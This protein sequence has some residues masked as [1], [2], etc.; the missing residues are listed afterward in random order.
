M[1]YDGTLYGGMPSQMPPTVKAARILLYGGAGLA[2]MLCAALM[3]AGFTATE[4]GGLT[5]IPLTLGITGAVLA[6][7]MRPGRR[8]IR[9]ALNVVEGVWTLLA[10]GAAGQGDPTGPVAMLFS[11]AVLVLINTRTARDYFH[12]TAM[13]TG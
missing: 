9:I 8:R 2:I 11:V 12:P 6:W 3:L 1:T 4:I 13:V 10:F 5:A 7:R